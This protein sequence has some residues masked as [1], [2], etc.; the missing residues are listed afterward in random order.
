MQGFAP[1]GSIGQGHNLGVRTARTQMAAGT[2]DQP[3]PDN[4]AT[5]GWVGACQPHPSQRL[6]QG[7]GHEMVV[8][9]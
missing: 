7:Q 5:H 2:D 3:I 6:T 1:G 9:F 8:T 4:H